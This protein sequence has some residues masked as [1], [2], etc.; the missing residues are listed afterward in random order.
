VD[1]SRRKSGIYRLAILVFLQAGCSSLQSP[2][3][4]YNEIIIV[5]QTGSA[6]RDVAVSSTESG[7]TFSCG[8][9]APRGICSNKF[10]PRPYRASPVQ[11][12]WMIGNGTRHSKIIELTLPP[13]FVVELPLRGV[14]VIDTQGQVST[15]LQQGAPGPH[16]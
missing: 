11:I 15:Y 13:S 5:N 9:I 8:N 2:T 10:P 6:V 1:N 12:D 3:Y 16:L 14:L 4:T 7:R